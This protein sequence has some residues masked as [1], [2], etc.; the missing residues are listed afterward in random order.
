M[1][2]IVEKITFDKI[3][4]IWAEQDGF[5]I[6]DL[7]NGRLSWSFYTTYEV[8]QEICKRKNSSL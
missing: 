2:Y 1:R 5:F 3:H 7:H 8:A 4:T 6:K